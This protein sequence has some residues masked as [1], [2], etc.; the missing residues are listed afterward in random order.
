MKMEEN[1]QK[2]YCNLRIIDLNPF[3][4]YLFLKHIY[5]IDYCFIII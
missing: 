5:L 3:Q 4:N 2:A 1:K